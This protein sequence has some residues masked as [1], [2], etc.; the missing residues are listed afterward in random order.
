MDDQNPAPAPDNGD[1][2]AQPTDPAAVPP[3]QDP[4]MPAPT[5][6][7][8]PADPGVGDAGS[9]DG[10]VPPQAPVGQ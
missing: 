5:E 6:P 10:S 2:G 4:G 8:A 7:A 9:G 1:G 3:A